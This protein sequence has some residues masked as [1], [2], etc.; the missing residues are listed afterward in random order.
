MKKIV[1]CV[2]CLVITLCLGACGDSTSSNDY[3][4][5]NDVNNSSSELSDKEKYDNALTLFAEKKYQEAIGILEN[6]DY[7][8]SKELKKTVA[9]VYACEL[10]NKQEFSNAYDYFKKSEDYLD[11]QKKLNMSAYYEGV[12]LVNSDQHWKSIEWFRKVLNDDEFKTL[13]EKHIIEIT[14]DLIGNAWF[15]SYT[16]SNGVT[17]QVEFKYFES[18]D[19][20]YI[21]HADKS[22]G[23]KQVASLNG[24][25]EVGAE[26]SKY[27]H[28][29]TTFGGT[30]DA[31]EFSFDSANSMY[32]YCSANS[33]GKAITGFYSAEYTPS[34]YYKIDII[35]YP[36]LTIPEIDINGKVADDSNDDTSLTESVV[37]SVNESSNVNTNTE[38]DSK[39]SNTNLKPSN[40]TGSNFTNNTN[41][42]PANNT[43][44]N[45]SNSNK[46]AHSYSKATCTKPAICS[47]GVTNGSALGHNWKAA[48]CKAPKTCSICGKTEGLKAD[49]TYKNEK[50]TLCGEKSAN[51]P[52]ESDI[53][54][55]YPCKLVYESEFKVLSY[56]ISNMDGYYEGKAKISIKMQIVDIRNNNDHSEYFGVK[57]YDGNGNDITKWKPYDSQY[58]TS[59]SVLSHLETGDVC[60]SEFEIPVNCRKIVLISEG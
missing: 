13:A 41:S 60:T 8:N 7:E 51:Y 43:N 4:N 1:C 32:V 42:K 36:T 34:V 33:I 9:Y 31:V 53:K 15:G 16:N 23:Y 39:P 11:S 55:E 48:T 5:S 44:S 59:G 10:F 27:Y 18:K 22:N 30:W 29:E 52:K 21:A 28:S 54:L 45:P 58:I 57:Y 49:H 20:L 19:N 2:L 14:T 35:S 47:C 38:L 37:S 56:S 24:S 26:Q 40:T 6:I 46:H 17:L 25:L 3:A 12:K 50:C